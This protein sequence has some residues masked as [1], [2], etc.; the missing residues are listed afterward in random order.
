MF[1]KEKLESE[2]YVRL[3]K[4]VGKNSFK[5]LI[6]VEELLSKR[7]KNEDLNIHLEKESFITRSNTMHYTNSVHLNSDGTYLR[8]NITKERG[9]K[10]LDISLELGVEG[11]DYSTGERYDRKQARVEYTF[12]N[13]NV[14]IKKIEDEK[15]DAEFEEK[16]KEETKAKVLELKN[17]ST[18]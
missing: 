5:T 11:F 2:E 16:K 1:T 12:E 8:S 13:G 4:Y 6:R 7:K 15:Y 9:S 17:K 3:Y 18:M 14:E 10:L